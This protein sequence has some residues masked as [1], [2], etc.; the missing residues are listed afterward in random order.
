MDAYGPN[1]RFSYIENDASHDTGYASQ[2]TV[3]RLHALYIWMHMDQ[4]YAFLTLKML[5]HMTI[6]VMENFSYLSNTSNK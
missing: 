3:L 6:T 2:N 4:I 5:L 1:V